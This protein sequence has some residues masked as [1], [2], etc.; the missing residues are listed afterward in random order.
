MDDKTLFI[1]DSHSAG[2]Y[3]N[4]DGVSCTIWDSEN[5]YAEIYSKLYNTPSAIYAMPG[6]CNRHYPVWFSFLVDEYKTNTA[7]IQSTYW[8]RYL[9]AHSERLD[10]GDGITKD[11]FVD[12]TQSETHR[13]SNLTSNKGRFEIMVGQFKELHEDFKGFNFN[14]SD[15]TSYHN[16]FEETYKYSKLWFEGLTHLQL[17]DY[18]SDLIVIDHL[19]QERDINVYVWCINNRVHIP[20]TK[21]LFGR[22]KR[23]KFVEQS[24]EDFLYKEHKMHIEQMHIDSEHYHRD[25]HTAIAKY[26]IPYIEKNY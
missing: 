17:R 9:F 6:A 2:F 20:N 10:W 14:F 7:F 21:D 1:G 24:A 4:A 16:V 23:V 25:V 22:F 13:Y 18:L 19:A 3:E 12:K 15:P 5:N 26:Y 11:H 8:N